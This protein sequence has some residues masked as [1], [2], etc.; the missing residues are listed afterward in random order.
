MGIVEFVIILAI[1]LLLVGTSRFPQVGRELGS[2]I[3][4]FKDELQSPKKQTKPVESPEKE[5]K[6]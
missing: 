4:N 5:V 6:S 1:V 3:R 2:A